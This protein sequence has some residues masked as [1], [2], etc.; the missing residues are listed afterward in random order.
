MGFPTTRWPQLQ[1][2]GGADA[3]ER[4][5]IITYLAEKYR[6]PVFSWLC[7]SGYS[8]D[9]ADELTQSFF[10]D[11]VLQRDLTRRADQEK[12][13]FRTFLL[14]ALKNHI[15]DEHR[16]GGAKRRK[17]EGARL[18]IDGEEAVQVASTARSPAEAFHHA[19]VCNL[20]HDVIQGLEQEYEQKNLRTHWE[21]FREKILDPI[22]EGAPAPSYESLRIKYGIPSTGKAAAMT[23]TVKR[24]F[25]SFLREAIRPH[26]AS[27]AD[28]DAEIAELLHIFSRSGA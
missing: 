5:T 21:V 12:G 4:Q 11:I 18:S 24:R 8:E 28:I 14:N 23:T 20:L 10:C 27:E 16:R 25:R 3:A 2:Y 13:H 19:W 17:P 1:A 6:P 15:T 7:Y 22:L 9:A 26:V